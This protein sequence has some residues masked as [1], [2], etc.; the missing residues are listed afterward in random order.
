MN[1]I[2][3]LK[4]SFE[5]YD[6]YIPP[7]QLKI[8]HIKLIKIELC[9]RQRKEMAKIEEKSKELK[10]RIKKTKHKSRLYEMENGENGEQDIL[11]NNIER[12]VLSD[13]EIEEDIKFD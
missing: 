11:V 1:T 13:E 2:K 7:T 4:L 6:A 12:E 5:Q 8:L 9:F 3:F 10:E